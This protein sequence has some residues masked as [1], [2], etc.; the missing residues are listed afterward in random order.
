MI[1][2]K[3]TNTFGLFI[4]FKIPTKDVESI[5]KTIM[6]YFDKVQYY[7]EY[8]RW[9]ACFCC[10]FISYENTFEYELGYR[11]V[12]NKETHKKL[13][14]NFKNSNEKRII[15]N[16]I[17]MQELLEKYDSLIDIEKDNILEIII[18]ISFNY[19]KEKYYFDINKII[20]EEEK[21]NE[22]NRDSILKFEDKDYFIKNS[23]IFNYIAK[24]YEII[25][26]YFSNIYLFDRE[27]YSC[28]MFFPDKIKIFENIEN[29][30]LLGE[31]YINGFDLK[32]K[33]LIGLENWSIDNNEEYYFITNYFN[34]KL[35]FQNTNLNKLLHKI[36][37]FGKKYC[38][39]IVEKL[40]KIGEGS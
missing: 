13:N 38:D 7:M 1:K 22:E 2:M 10:K 27:N 4:A 26:S 8:H 15:L 36:Q 20:S 18:K 32:I 30:K 11:F 16:I 25:N 24:K 33:S 14:Y 35:D 29:Q 23:E 21:E 39:L 40:D 9:R 12:L 34:F 17:L 31:A 37:D 19:E 5:Y 6:D 3:K 28:N